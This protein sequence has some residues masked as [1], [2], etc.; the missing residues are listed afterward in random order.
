M[1]TSMIKRQ[2][3]FSLIEAVIALG[4]TVVVMTATISASRTAQQNARM[5][6]A[7]NE[8]QQL[9]DDGVNLAYAYKKANAGSY[10]AVFSLSNVGDEAYYV[11]YPKEF[12]SANCRQIITSGI[13]HGKC[14]T[15][16]T[17]Y[18]GGGTSIIGICKYVETP[19]TF[20]VIG[21]LAADSCTNGKVPFVSGTNK[22]TLSE[23]V[24]H[25]KSSVALGKPGEMIALRNFSSNDNSQY[26]AISSLSPVNSNTI[27]P[28]ADS[29]SFSIYYR[30]VNIKYGSINNYTL[31]VKVQ[32]KLDKRIS[33]E[34]TVQ[35][36]D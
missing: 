31:T 24:N 25:V 18:D 26:F 30:S 23:M 7:A 13:N 36:T 5:T 27:N 17:D 32:N 3:A 9:V 33:L 22:M 28:M 29:E 11:F 35:L 2:S 4:L 12:I 6:I 1:K 15:T 34:K 16:N 10:S 19:P 8:V 14:F 20:S 21:D